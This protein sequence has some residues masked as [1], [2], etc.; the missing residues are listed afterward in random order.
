MKTATGDAVL[1]AY[2]KAV[3]NLE[4]DPFVCRTEVSAGF[5][6]PDGQKRGDRHGLQ[7]FVT[8]CRYSDKLLKTAPSTGGLVCNAPH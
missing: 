7:V 6:I 5:I 2:T 4:K 1:R 8:V 3:K